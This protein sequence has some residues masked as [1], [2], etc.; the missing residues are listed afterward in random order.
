MVNRSNSRPQRRRKQ[1]PRIQGPNPNKGTITSAAPSALSV[2][3][4]TFNPVIRRSAKSFTVRHRELVIASIPGS[5]AFTLQSYLRLNPGLA[6]TFAW[7]APQAQQWDQYAVRSLV[8]EYI[9]SSGTAVAGDIILSPNYDAS[10]PRP[11]TE[12]QAVNNAGAIVSSCWAPTS[13][14]FDIKAMMGLGPRKF[15]RSANVSGDLKTFDIGTLA[16]CTVNQTGTTGIGKLFLD[17]EFEFFTPQSDPSTSTAPLYTSQ[18]M[19]SVNQAFPTGVT[20]KMDFDS[21]AYDPLGIGVTVG[22]F[23]TPP[24]GSYRVLVTHT[25]IDTSSEV[26]IASIRI[27]KNGVFPAVPFSQA[28]NSEI[29]SAAGASNQFSMTI[30]GIFNMNGTDTLAIWLTLTGAAG[31]LSSE[32]PM[33][34]WTLA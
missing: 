3:T 27:A 25:V 8:A 12:V 24:A 28:V 13:L 6:A 17:Y 23:F 11:T 5:V 10:D 22:G 16:V 9:P 29:D 32:Q 21:V 34:I 19:N 33:I 18:F 14:K 20:T 31:T 26:F 2:R 1:K 7:L 30:Q 15:I 4:T